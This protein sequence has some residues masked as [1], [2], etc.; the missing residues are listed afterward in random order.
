MPKKKKEKHLVKKE[1]EPHTRSKLLSSHEE[2]IKELNHTGLRPWQIAET[3]IN[4]YDLPHSAITAKQVS[5]FIGY[6]VRKKKH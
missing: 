2:E 3:L 1:E 4:K 6:R 5:D